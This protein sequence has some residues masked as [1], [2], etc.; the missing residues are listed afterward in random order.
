MLEPTSPESMCQHSL[1]TS[2]E[3]SVLHVLASNVDLPLLVI[4]MVT[5]SFKS[6]PF[7]PATFSMCFN[8]CDPSGPP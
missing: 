7:S 6:L 2:K 8:F 3:D 4:F 1:S 5:V